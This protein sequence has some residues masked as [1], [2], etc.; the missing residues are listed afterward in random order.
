MLSLDN[1]FS[2]DELRAWATR[3]ERLVTEPVRYVA[4][5]KLD[6][7]AISLQYEHGRFTVGATRGDGVTGEDVTENLRTIKRHPETAEGQARPGAARG[8]RRGVHAARGVRGAEPAPGRGGRAAVRQRRATPPPAAC[9]RRT[10]ASPRRATSPLFCYQLGAVAGRSRAAHARGDAR[11]GCAELGFPVNPNIEAFDDLDA[12]FAFCERHGGEPPLARL[13]HRRRRREGRR[14]RPARGDGLHVARAALGDRVQVPARREDHDPPRHHG[15]HR[16]HRPGDAVRGARAGVRRRRQRRAWRRCTTRT[17]SRARTCGPGDTVDR[18]PRRRRHPRGRRARPRE[19]AE[20]ARA[21]GSSRRSARSAASRSCASRARRTTTA[22][23]STARRSGCSASCTGRAA[24]RWT[25]KGS[26]RSACASSSTPACSRTRPTSTS[27][28]SSKL[29][30]LE[31]IG[32]R[33][34][35]SCSSTRS[36]GRRRSRCGACSSGS[37]STTSGRPRRRRSRA[38]SADL[39][40]SR[41]R[42]EDDAHRD[43]RCRADDRAEHRSGSSR[44][45]ATAISSTGC[46]RRA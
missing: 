3:V 39:D 9:A 13:R 1:A 30:P 42:P 32:E 4:E 26:A 2:F 36:Q 12:V 40:A 37:A 18:A 23:T 28:P 21:A 35:R 7:L 5:P 41:T 46:A 17:T 25:S 15:E 14:P 10:R 22:S 16:P 45:T 31:R 29:V 19:A 8:A 27:S 11:R 6:G 44:S 24:A 20:A 43:R 38:A 34:A 33:S